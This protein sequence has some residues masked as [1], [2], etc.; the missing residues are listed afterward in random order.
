MKKLI[1]IKGKWYILLG[2]H[3][4]Y[5]CTS[6]LFDINNDII[7]KGVIWENQPFFYEHEFWYGKLLRFIVRY[8]RVIK[9]LFI[10]DAF[11][12]RISKSII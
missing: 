5:Y 6:S 12:N 4:G 8:I 7:N 3:G 11:S 1:N 10:R 9:Q 2:M